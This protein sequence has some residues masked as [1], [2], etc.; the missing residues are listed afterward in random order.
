MP[1]LYRH[2]LEFFKVNFEDQTFFLFQPNFFFISVAHSEVYGYGFRTYEY[3]PAEHPRYHMTTARAQ[4]VALGMYSLRSFML[5][6]LI[7]LF[8]IVVDKAGIAVPP[9]LVSNTIIQPMHK[10]VCPTSEQ[11]RLRRV[12]AYAQTRQSLRCSHTQSIDAD[13]DSDLNLDFS[14][15]WTRQHGCLLEAV[16]DMR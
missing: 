9:F 1:F 12:C 5:P 2:I 8:M 10:N 4:E 14:L 7:A 16:T 15:C 3:L 13:E 6:H 11:W